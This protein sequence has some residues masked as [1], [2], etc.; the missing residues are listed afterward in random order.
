MPTVLRIGSIILFFT[1]YDC[2]GR[3]V[4]KYWLRDNETVILADNIGFSK[5]ELMKLRHIVI[6]NFQL[7]K[8]SWNEHCKNTL[9]KEYKKK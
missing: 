1:S 6:A 5:A 2:G 4:C 7:I 9:K 8:K 3:K